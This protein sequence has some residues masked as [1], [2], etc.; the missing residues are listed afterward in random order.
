MNA[1]IAAQM[2]GAD[3]LK[4]RKKRGTVIWALV[5]AVLP[6]I[7]LYAVKAGQH[8]SNPV[9]HGPA[10]GLPGLQDGDGEWC[11]IVDRRRDNGGVGGKLRNNIIA[12]RSARFPGLDLV[13]AG[14]GRSR[15]VDVEVEEGIV[16]V[17]RVLGRNQG[18]THSR[19]G[20]VTV[21]SVITG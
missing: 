8:S 2:T 15:P 19:A 11:G 10:G 1:T 4:L 20:I 5:L 9:A 7:V 17:H 13:A 18:P 12:A 6:V 3:F 16:P 14:A 21:D